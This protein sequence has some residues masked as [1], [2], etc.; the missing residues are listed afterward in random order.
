MKYHIQLL[1]YYLSFWN[2]I[3]LLIIFLINEATI[4]F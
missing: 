1:L 4:I 2:K 3:F